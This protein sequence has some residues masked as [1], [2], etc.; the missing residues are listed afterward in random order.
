MPHID[1]H[2]AENQQGEHDEQNAHIHM[3]QIVAETPVLSAPLIDSLRRSSQ[4]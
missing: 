4:C 2:D 3:E 1:V